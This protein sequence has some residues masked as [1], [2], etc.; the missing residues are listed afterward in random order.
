MEQEMNGPVAGENPSN[1]TRLWEKS[2]TMDEMRKN[3]NNWSLAGDAGMT[4]VRVHN[5]FNDFIMLANTQFVENRVYDEDVSSEDTAKESNKEETQEK[6][7]EQ[8]EAELIPKVSEALQLGIK[9]TE[10]AFE[11]LDSNVV[12]SDSEDD[13]DT[14]YRV[15]PILEAK[16]CGLGMNDNFMCEKVMKV[17]KAFTRIKLGLNFQLYNMPPKGRSRRNR[18]EDDE[19]EIR[20]NLSTF[21]PSPTKDIVKPTIFYGNLDEDIDSWLKNFDRIATANEWSR[22]RKLNTLPAFLR[23][24]AAEFLRISRG[25]QKGRYSNIM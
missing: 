24:R 16:L 8:R 2:W 19:I 7:R 20:T 10:E 22:E 13:D 15:D 23:D 6:T 17:V 12:N 3:A 11:A 14:N 1:G 5:V 18:S 4:G 21:K 25:R 9:V